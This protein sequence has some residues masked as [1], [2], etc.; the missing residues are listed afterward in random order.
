MCL[1]VLSCLLSGSQLNW[2]TCA[3]NLYNHVCLLKSSVLSNVPS[4]KCQS[5]RFQLKGSSL[6]KFNYREINSNNFTFFLVLLKHLQLAWNRT[7]IWNAVL[8][9]VCSIRRAL[10]Q[11]TSLFGRGRT[12]LNCLSCNFPSS[13]SRWLQFNFE[14][15]GLTSIAMPTVFRKGQQ[16]HRE[17]KIAATKSHCSLFE[18]R[19]VLRQRA[20][21]VSDS[22][23]NLNPLLFQRG[24]EVWVHTKYGN[25]EQAT[26]LVYK[27]T[28]HLE[29]NTSVL[30][31]IQ[32]YVHGLRD[33]RRNRLGETK[34]VIQK[35]G[36][37]VLHWLIGIDA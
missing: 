25:D 37:V 16:A 26:I 6:S 14:A 30:L 23:H 18:K 8:C 10:R 12:V 19:P 36:R 9:I 35:R 15:A 22:M 3:S 27:I 24:S 34:W 21:K 29:D 11:R 4:S 20:F 17:T 32:S 7:A 1:L 33:L 28:G 13:Y 2:L 31:C 5:S